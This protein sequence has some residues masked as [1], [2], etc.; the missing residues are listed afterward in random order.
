MDSTTPEREGRPGARPGARV[1]PDAD[2]NGSGGHG[3]V[4]ADSGGFRRFGQVRVVR[5]GAEGS[6]A[7]EPGGA[8]PPALR[9][10]AAAFGDGPGGEAAPARPDAGAGPLR[11]PADRPRT[12]TRPEGRPNAAAARRTGR[13]PRGRGVFARARHG[14]RAGTPPIRAR[15]VFLQAPPLL[16]PSPLHPSEIQWAV[17]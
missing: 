14:F 1:S 6:G 4:W 7:G 10:P 5:A 9:V 12:R 11:L 13:L 3:T 15:F 17:A 2:S 8:V 16:F